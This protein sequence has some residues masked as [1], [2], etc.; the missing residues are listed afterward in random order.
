MKG[1]MEENSASS[2]LEQTLTKPEIHHQ[3]EQVFRTAANEAFYE[4]VFDF[5]VLYM[6]LPPDALVLDAGCGIGAHAVRLAKRGLQVTAVDFAP[7][8]LDE[9]ASYVA[10]QGVSDR[11]HIQRE[12]LL[13]LSLADEQF[14]C[15]L[16]WGVLMHISQIDTAIAE[17]C[18]VVKPG[19]FLIL[20]EDNM[21][22]LQGWLRRGSVR[23]R[24]KQKQAIKTAAGIEYWSET[25]GGRLMA[26]E[27]NIP[28][29][30]Q[31]T[32][33]HGFTLMTRR[34]GQFTTLYGRSH[35][36]FWQRLIH[37]FN[38]FWFETIKWPQPAFGNILIL[39]K[40]A[41]IAD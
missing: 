31:A 16:C 8:V 3:W 24:H 25:T 9:A 41:R 5:L 7:P 20:G 4:R 26:R 13:T 36:V 22:S 21:S 39:K 19:G 15:V 17:L 1:L 14:D 32:N 38:Q 6:A 30:I 40:V 2:Q 29:F 23:L 10:H 37:R 33:A 35:N 34:A 18:R 27:S 12:N 11:V 28:W